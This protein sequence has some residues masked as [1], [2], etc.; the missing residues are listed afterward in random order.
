LPRTRVASLD[1]AEVAAARL[2]KYWNLGEAPLESV[3]T[4]IEDAGGVVVELDIDSAGSPAAFDGLSGWVSG[5]IPVVV[6]AASATDDR[7]RFSL[8]HELGHL[9]MDVGDAATKDAERFAHRFAAAF[10]VP[11]ETARR[12]LGY[13]RLRLDMREL[14][15]LKRKHGLSM[16]AWVYRALDLGIIDAAHGRNLFAIFSA[17]GWRKDE[18][19]KFEGRERPLRLRQLTVRAHAEGLIS[20]AQ[21]SRICPSAVQAESSDAADTRSDGGPRTLGMLPQAER[22]RLLV[23]AA[24]RMRGDYEACGALA[25]FDALEV[26]DPLQ[27][28]AVEQRRGG[29][30]DRSIAASRRAAREV[31]DE[32]AHA[33]SQAVGRNAREGGHGQLNGNRQGR[34]PR[35][36]SEPPSHKRGASRATHGQR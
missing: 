22:E 10:I 27:P 21:A 9:S 28:K 4:A 17:N 12:E 19:A 14:S 23:D 20:S 5:G 29:D 24:S 16:Q 36:A 26:L 18:P 30:R 7:R 34:A 33:M 31:R 2:R 8:A 6:V 35:S 1:D 3:T 11:P 15:M 25:G 32:S 13:R